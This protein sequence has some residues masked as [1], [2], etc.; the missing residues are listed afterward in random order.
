MSLSATGRGRT[1]LE[2][3]EGYRCCLGFVCLAAGATREQIRGKIGP[4][5]V[6]VP[7]AGLTER[8]GILVCSSQLT[9]QAMAT[10]DTASTTPEEKEAKLLE[11]FEDS[12]YELEFVG[13]HTR[14]FG[15]A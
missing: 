13:K 8:S 11:I 14:M 5:D 2:N 15:D 3:D 12:P 4:D 10:N 9:R 7:I 6:G 1:Y